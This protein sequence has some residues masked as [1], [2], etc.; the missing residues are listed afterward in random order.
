MSGSGPKRA[1]TSWRSSSDSL[2]SVSSSWLRTKRP[3]DAAR[4]DLR[5]VAQRA[6]QRLRLAARQR[7]VQ[8]L[9]ADEVEH[10]VQLVAVLVAEERAHVLRRQVDLAEQHRL[11][12]AAAQIGAQVAQDLVRVVHRALDQ[13]RHGVDAEPREPLLEPEAHHLRELVADLRVGQVE[14]RLV[15]IELV[16]VVLLG[17]AVIGPVRALL[18]REHDV[19]G[20]LRAASRRPRRRSRGTASPGPSARPGTTGAGRRCGS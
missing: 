20:L 14:V 18:V 6:R 7:E 15:R 19:A 3:S 4:R 10:H 1:N 5:E 9:V 17:L 2:S 12:V 16:Q 11:A 8:R 13:E